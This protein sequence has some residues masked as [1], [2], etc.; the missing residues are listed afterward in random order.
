MLVL[1]ACGSRGGES[2]PP[3]PPPPVPV[4]NDAPAPPITAPP[5]FEVASPADKLVAVGRGDRHT[6][7]VRA[8][9]AVDCWGQHRAKAAPD[10]TV[11]RVQGIDDA[12]GIT[13]NAHCFLRR[14]GDVACLAPDAL[15]AVP[16]AGITDARIGDPLARC[17][18]DSKGGL[19][20]LDHDHKAWKVPNVTDA[21]AIG[22][23]EYVTCIV[24]KAGTVAC[25]SASSRSPLRTLQG[26]DQ[27]TAIALV[28]G[29]ENRACAVTRGRVRCFLVDAYPEPNEPYRAEF[30]HEGRSFDLPEP[31]PFIGATQLV[32]WSTGREGKLFL[33]AV[34]GGKVVRTDFSEL[35]VLPVLT[36]AAIHGR[37]C[38]IRAQ[39]SVACWGTNAGGALAQPTTLS[40]FDVPPSPVV[41]L[42]GVV[43]IA[44]GTSKSFAITADGRVWWWGHSRFRD[45]R[46][47]PTVLPLGLGPEKLV[48]VIAT[49]KDHVCMRSS[50]GEVWCQTAATDNR[51]E[52]LDTDGVRDMAP[53]GV[54]LLA[55]RGDGTAEVHAIATTAFHD[56]PMTI[57]QLTDPEAVQYAN[58]GDESCVRR[59]DGTVLCPGAIK[60]LTAATELVAGRDHACAVQRG[61][62]WCWFG[63]YSEQPMV[64]SEVPG[65]R[66]VTD[67]ASSADHL[68]A[69][70]DGG[71][72]S[73]WRFQVEKGDGE[74]SRRTWLPP[75][76]VIA[77][78]AVDVELGLAYAEQ[79]T[80]SFAL[81]GPQ[82]AGQYGCVRMADR[83]IRCWG[84]NLFGELGDGSFDTAEAPIGV[85]L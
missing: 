59:R 70:H 42:A 38:A 64:I 24:R 44:L 2:P 12:V 13:Q 26:V 51:I 85:K 63:A 50:A 11:R 39:G 27:V 72:V 60:D 30:I 55:Y 31:E 54:G 28:G 73:C 35:T 62:V 69:V 75:Q 9:G 65:L 5:P 52:Q 34:V 10:P 20:C 40:L 83:T 48:Q 82:Q 43:D 46:A 25:G 67:L 21:V 66:E 14:T 15:T 53:D 81:H 16:L 17:Y 8:S 3:P 47:V 4:T 56:A 1:A 84:S 19:T 80:E 36:D 6:C 79:Y 77:S 41:G 22:S 68:C 74:H 76:Q 18:I 33:E 61:R 7:V 45:G 58:L 32:M 49:V 29:F 71:R 57:T 23:S 37:E 78:G